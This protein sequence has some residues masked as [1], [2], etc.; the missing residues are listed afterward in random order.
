MEWKRWK[1]IIISTSITNYYHN[2][3]TCHAV[4]STH[5]T[6][7]STQHEHLPT[8]HKYSPTQYEC[9]STQYEFSPTQHIYSPGIITWYLITQPLFTLFIENSTFIYNNNLLLLL[10]GVHISPFKTE[11]IAHTANYKRHWL[12]ISYASGSRGG[13]SSFL[14]YKGVPNTLKVIESV[15]SNIFFKD[16][17]AFIP[18]TPKFETTQ[19]LKSKPFENSPVYIVNMQWEESDLK[20]WLKG[21]G[22]HPVILDQCCSTVD[23]DGGLL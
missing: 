17:N 20:T 23:K 18:E 14:W 15:N 2:A 4:S 7:W 3:F 1:S 5:Y 21:S 8:Q 19:E 22:R 11:W 13:I 16:W 12:W 6:A 9:S 10:T